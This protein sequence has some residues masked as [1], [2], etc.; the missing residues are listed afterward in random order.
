M[1]GVQKPLRVLCTREVQKSLDQS[2]H[3]LLK[4]QIIAL[5]LQGHYTVQKTKISGRN[6]TEFFFSGLS[7]QTAV[8][9]KSFEGV[10]I[11]W[12]EEAQS[13]SDA[14]LDILVPTIRKAGSSIWYTF[15][16]QL[17][18]DPVYQRYVVNPP[19]G[20]H[21]I[22]MNWEDNPWFDDTALLNEM[23]HAEATMAPEM[24]AH[25]WGGMCLPAV[26]GAIYFNAI[27]DMEAGKRIGRVPHDPL[28]KTHVIFDLGFNDATAIILAQVMGSEVRIVHY[29]EGR[30]RT[31]AEYNAELK[32]WRPNNQPPNWG[33]MWLPHDGFATRHQTGTSDAQI[34]QQFGWTVRKVPQTTIRAGID[35]TREVLSRVYIDSSCERL[36]ECLKR[37]RWNTTIKGESKTPLHDEFSHGADAA[38]YLSLSIDQ[39]SN[40]DWGG[41]D[42]RRNASRFVA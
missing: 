31:L 4:D 40:D 14:S 37:Y 12:V 22:V 1:L 32:D 6:G 5:D 35:R 30:Q 19:E 39:L 41:R 25:V 23:R 20:H 17:E 26:E 7:D 36:I 18:T 2:V 27:A 9:I 21:D 13:V 29:I 33:S 16:P 3:Q 11:C 42:V 15:N 28:L 10:D 34:M 8:S 24:F 38:R